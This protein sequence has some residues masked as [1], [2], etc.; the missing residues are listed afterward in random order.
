MSIAQSGSSDISS[1]EYADSIINTVREPLIVLDRELRVVS[2]SRSFY[3]V[4]K[5]NPED[6][7]GQLIYDLGNKQ[8]DIPK[9]RELLETIL[10]QKTAFDNYEVEH[11]FTNIGRRIM[12]LNARQIQRMAGEERIILLAIE[13]ITER[14][15]TET[16]LEK[17][18]K[19]LESTKISEDAAREYAES[20]IN[21]I[22]EPLIALDQ[23]LR[24]VSASR[25]FYEVF[26]VNP[27]ETVGQL[28]YDLGNKQW[29]I[30]KLRELLETILPQKTAFDNYEVEHNFTTIGRRVMLLNARQ[31]QRVAGKGRIILLAIEDITVRKAA[32]RTINLSEKRYRRLFEAAKDGVLILETES[33]KIIDVNPFLIELTGYSKDDFI[34]K[35][36][37]EIGAFKDIDASRVSFAELLTKGYIRYEDLPLRIKDGRRVDVEFVSNVYRVGDKDEI[38]CNIR[39]ITMRRRAEERVQLQFEHLNALRE[40]DRVIAS[41]FDLS[42]SLSEILTHV[43]IELGVDAAAIL[44]LNPSSK[45][46]EFGAERGFRVKAIRRA[47]IRLGDSYAGLAAMERRMVMIPDLRSE[48]NNVL[49]TEYL[50]GDNFVC[51][52]G[53]PL[54]AKGQVKGVLE[55]CNRTV[56]SPETEWFDFLNT[57]AGQTAIAIENSTLFESLQRSNLELA[58]AY[59]STIEGWSRALDMRDRETEGHSQR[60]TEMTVDLARAFGLGE[61]E[62]VQVR[63][64]A[65]L[66]DIGKMGVPDG[67]LLK[68]GPL[69]DEEWVAMKKHPT[70]AYE[71]LSPIR[72]LRMAMDIPHC[73]HEKWDGTGYPH[74]LKGIQI[75]ICARIFSV[76]DVWDA[77]KSERPYRAG[78]PE[79]K[80][81]EHIRSS[82]GTQFDPQ[83]VDAFMQTPMLGKRDKAR[84]GTV[85]PNAGGERGAR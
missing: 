58:L 49:L 17:T 3:E 73:H 63:W 20:I 36:I 35:S 38:Q 34:G 42:L 32:A 62:L 27:E 5:V 19:E 56:L 51:Y 65:L 31:I 18:R 14:R 71:M 66:H 15:E 72:Y 79:E 75:P 61:A 53:V 55:V 4:F 40:I 59:D 9:L 33:G 64:G 13:D 28:I 48:P 82:S 21:T 80:I 10:P 85:F 12:L 24:V 44:I 52:Y 23:D 81:S 47:L 57:L 41:N 7:V 76:V 30:P 29:D 16:G 22:R 77:L 69:T 84:T 50:A 2:V 70:F 37:W 46:L 43:T 45:I 54:I 1:L 60:V 26:K 39:D 74:G 68:P 83:V 8:W 67:I 78:W 25:S 11:N 6:T